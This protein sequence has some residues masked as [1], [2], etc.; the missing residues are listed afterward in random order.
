MTL[1]RS[2]LF[3]PANDQRRLQKAAQSEADAVILDLEDGVPVAGKDAARGDIVQSAMTLKSAGKGLI[4][5]INAPWRTACSDL[6]ASL[7]AKADLIMV[8]KVE[9]E[10][11]IRAIA[12]MVSEFEAIHATTL[13]TEL[14]ALI[15]SP[16]A[17]YRLAEIAGVE[18]VSGLALGTEDYSASAGFEPTLNG[19]LFAA[20][21]TV[22]AASAFGVASY[23]VP[24]SIAA[25]KDGAGFRDACLR[26][27]S[28][29]GTGA[30]CI[31]PLQVG[32]A[33]EVFQATPE[34]IATARR[35][36]ACWSEA[37][38][39]GLSVV[40]LDGNMIDP[41]VVRRA[42]NLLKSIS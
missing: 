42:R 41:P 14:I 27:R 26:S 31:H 24:F 10:H 18:R 38:A 19:L 32:I 13:N 34:E 29:G 1:W 15:E 37:E 17:I 3:V 16:R 36:V 8:P 21:S 33:N 20:Q 5:R 7:L 11:R 9:T 39:N 6:E 2:L 40:V 25:Y 22:H 30:L 12:E 28:M 35:I 4:V 23:A